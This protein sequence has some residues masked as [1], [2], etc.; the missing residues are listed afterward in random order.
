MTPALIVSD[1]S[2]LDFGKLSRAGNLLS[3]AELAISK[4]RAGYE[5]NLF[6]K[7]YTTYVKIIFKA[8][9]QM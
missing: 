1:E 9:I 4:I 7:T 2:E 6:C 5:L 8:N 3:R